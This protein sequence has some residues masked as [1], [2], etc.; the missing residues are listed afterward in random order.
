MLLVRPATAWADPEL[1]K[2]GHTR[3]MRGAWVASVANINFPSQSGLPR[4]TQQQELLRILDCLQEAR[5]NAIFFQ[6]RPEGDALYK[7]PLEPWSRFLGGMPGADPGYD[8]LQFLVKQ[9]HARNIEVH[10]WLNPYRARGLPQTGYPQ[11]APHLGV[12]Q[13]DHV[14]RYRP[15]EWM[16][17]AAPGVRARLLDVCRDLVTRYPIDGIHFDDY[18]YP[19]PDAGQ[20][21]PDGPSWA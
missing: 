15:Y 19:Y 6:V 18:F 9:A 2:V 13:P 5:F 1:V 17:P 14:F 4:E 3:Q 11:A 7:S 21:F 8:P 16:D 20:P 10:A 12:E